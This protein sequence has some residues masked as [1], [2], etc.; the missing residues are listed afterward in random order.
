M[1]RAPHSLKLVFGEDD[2]VKLSGPD[3]ELRI[4]R[5]GAGVY[6]I[7]YDFR[8]YPVNPEH[9]TAAKLHYD[10]DFSP[11]RTESFRDIR[12][13]DGRLSL[14]DGKYRLEVELSSGT[15]ALSCNGRLIHGG[16]V[17]SSDT[18]LPRYPLRAHGILPSHVSATFNFPLTEGDRFFRS[19]RQGGRYRQA[20]PPFYDAQSGFP[21]VSRL[22]RRSAL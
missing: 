19:G 10:P 13:T 17:G 2:P 16:P 9:E 6:E 4:E 15:V 3:A 1:K 21:R 20:Q 18:V 22:L 7:R 12:T 8:T 11:E 5:L 14:T